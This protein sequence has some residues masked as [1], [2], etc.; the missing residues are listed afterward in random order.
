M[1]FCARADILKAHPF[2][3]WLAF[4]PACALAVKDRLQGK[5]RR[6][7]REFLAAQEAARLTIKV[8]NGDDR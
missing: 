5:V 6:T 1:L 2:A 4:L 7:H 8:M 3:F